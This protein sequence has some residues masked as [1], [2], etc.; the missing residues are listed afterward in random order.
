LYV[1]LLSRRVFA[2][3]AA[4][5]CFAVF[6]GGISGQAAPFQARVGAKSYVR[7][8]GLTAVVTVN[9]QTAA[10]LH[11]T[12]GGLNPAQR[13]LSV[14]QRL[15]DLVAAG[16]TANQISAVSCGREG[17]QVQGRG[18]P[19]LTATRGE[20]RAQR[21]TAR[22]LA[23]SWAGSLKRLLSEPPLIVSER[24]LLLPFG[25]AK[26]LSIGGAAPSAGISVSGGD[27]RI[28]QF[29]YDAPK[30]RL[31]VR[32][33]DSGTV[34][35]NVQSG[36][37]VVPIDI[38]VRKYAAFV[39]SHVTV[40]VTG[41]PNAP[42]DLVQTA[43]YLGLKR[44]LNA[45]SGAQVRLLQTPKSARS[46]RPGASLTRRIEVRVAGAD[47]L[48]VI[49][50]PLITVVNQPLPAVSAV[51]LYYSNNPEQ[52]RGSQALFSA[53][54]SPGQPI[55]LDYHHQNSSGKPLIFHSDVVNDSDKTVSVYLMDGVAQPEVDTVQ[56]GQ[57]A[58]AAFLQALDNGIGLVLEV[59]PHARVPLAVQAFAPLLTVSGILEVQQI[60]GTDGALSLTVAADDDR[61]A[62]ASSPLNL[63][64]AIEQT[65]G[66]NARL[67]S[68]PAAPLASGTLQETSPYVFGAPRVTL[69]SVYAVGGQ[70]TYLRLG[71]AE[72]LKNAAGTQTLW[73]NYGV[74]YYISLRLTNPTSRPRTVVV[75]F[76]PEAGLAAGVFEVADQPL[77]QFGPMPPPTEEEVTRVRLQPGE[78]KTI[79]IR[80]LLL[81]GSAYPASLIVHAL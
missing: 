45:T 52:V 76:A 42:A 33:I 70:W 31:F 7:P 15:T 68:A 77:L 38:A 51:A 47:L 20:A 37:S 25:S 12:A 24:Q 9:D 30:R 11:T 55:R 13:A 73:G 10:T 18:L 40:R 17:W 64:E 34:R 43:I 44:A 1:A 71:N 8:H 6:L 39:Q 65:A 69:D 79:R 29:T 56:I 60:G 26:T 3:A 53:P 57:R 4:L 46:L 78:D 27:S 75:L 5:F 23:Q 2:C 16:L 49:A 81:N 63:A 32:G 58:G 50:A 67:V 48:P 54:L 59:P 19:L 80:T 66:D 14:K 74:S 62:L 28:V 21:Q 22:H 36:D 61:E 72:S 35:L 41:R